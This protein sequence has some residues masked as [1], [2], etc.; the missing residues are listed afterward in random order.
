[1]ACSGQSEE[2]AERGRGAEEGYDHKRTRGGDTGPI[3]K[4]TQEEAE[5]RTDRTRVRRAGEVDSIPVELAKTQAAT[6][7]PAQAEE[8]GAGQ[9]PGQGGGQDPRGPVMD[10]PG[11][12]MPRLKGVKMCPTLMQN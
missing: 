7:T 1:M 3:C 4:Q 5:V 2:A 12:Q 6:D 9:G 10:A 8:A 11:Q